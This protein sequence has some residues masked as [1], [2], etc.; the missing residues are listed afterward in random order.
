MVGREYNG[1]IAVLGAQLWCWIAA[2]VS[3][4]RGKFDARFARQCGSGR[5][6]SM[7]HTHLVFAIQRVR[8]VH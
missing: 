7:T 1:E 5:A 6:I 4:G 3:A 8:T 2:R